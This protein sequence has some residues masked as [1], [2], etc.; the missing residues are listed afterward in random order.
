MIRVF[1][2]ILKAKHKTFHIKRAWVELENSA[3]KQSTQASI[4]LAKQIYTVNLVVHS[5]PT[6]YIKHTL[7][8]SKTRLKRFGHGLPT[9]QNEVLIHLNLK[10]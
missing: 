3:E 1:S 10:S 7:S 6:L 9:L 4:D 8:K 5:I 2:F